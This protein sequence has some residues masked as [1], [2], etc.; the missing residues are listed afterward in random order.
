MYRL[1]ISGSDMISPAT[2]IR[3]AGDP[4]CSTRRMAPGFRM[5]DASAG[6]EYRNTPYFVQ[7][8]QKQNKPPQH[9]IMH[10]TNRLMVGCN[11]SV[12]P[13]A[14]LSRATRVSFWRRSHLLAPGL[15]VLSSV[16]QSTESCRSLGIQRAGDNDRCHSQERDSFT[17][18]SH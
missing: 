7:G 14:H 11:P 15:S 3:F 9:S 1:A 4:S 12:P 6:M 2:H 8:A 17:G 18:R 13:C 10:N 5:I 16:V